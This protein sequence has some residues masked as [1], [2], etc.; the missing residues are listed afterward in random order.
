MTALKGRLTLSVVL[1]VCLCLVLHAA[2]PKPSQ[3]KIRFVSGPPVEWKRAGPEDVYG[4]QMMQEMMGVEARPPELPAKYAAVLRLGLRPGDEQSADNWCRGFIPYAMRPHGRGEFYE[5]LGKHPEYAVSEE[6]KDRLLPDDTLWAGRDE[7]S[8]V[9]ILYAVSEDDA[10]TLASA[11]LAWMDQS[12]QSRHADRK[13]YLATWR[14]TRDELAPAVAKLQEQEETTQAEL[15]KLKKTTSYLDD[16]EAGLAAQQLNREVQMLGIEL[17]GIRARAAAIREERENIHERQR[18]A[19]EF[20]DTYF[21]ILSKLVILEVTE[22]VNA[23]GVLARM[24]AA[25]KARDLAIRY[26]ELA[27]RH[28]QETRQRESQ[29]RDLERA[30]MEIAS[31]ERLLANPPFDD[32]PPVLQG[33]KVLICP[34]ERA[35][36]D[37]VFDGRRGQRGLGKKDS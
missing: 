10:Q 2:E 17:T 14:Q 25:A 26:C 3:D 13:Q 11:F 37:G 23:A 24:H 5:W 30:Q 6:Q 27:D 21:E 1:S 35:A 28:I 33:G 31:L 36:P 20:R 29:A 12:A 4:E 7:H 18:K 34:V 15:E 8:V 9:V 16:G 19:N 32:R 22:N